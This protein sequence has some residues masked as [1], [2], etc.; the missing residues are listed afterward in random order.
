MYEWWLK[1]GKVYANDHWDLPYGLAP[2][3]ITSVKKKKESKHSPKEGR[4]AKDMSSRDLPQE[5]EEA[6]ERMCHR[7]ELKR[8]SM[9]TSRSEQ[10]VRN[11]SVEEELQ[12]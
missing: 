10:R 11:G 1:L 4:A 8:G 5:G 3:F 9:G 7:E 6:T 12:N 2:E